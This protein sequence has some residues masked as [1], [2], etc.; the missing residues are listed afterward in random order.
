MEERYGEAYYATGLGPLPYRRDDR[1]LAFFRGVAREIVLGLAPRRVFDAG[2]AMGML[3]ESLWDLGVEAH[4]VDLSRYAIAHVRPDMQPYCRVGSVGEPPEGRYDLVT[5]IEVLEH[6]DRDESE[7]AIAALTTVT[8]TI[9][10]SSTPSDFD[11]PTHVNVRPPIAWIRAFA[12]HGFRVDLRFDATF[13]SPQAM[14]LRRAERYDDG[15]IEELYAHHVLIRSALIEREQ[16]IGRLNAQAEEAAA[17]AE[18]A[19]AAHRAELAAAQA[20]RMQ[21][22]AAAAAGAAQVE[23]ERAAL[24]ALRGRLAEARAELGE[25]RARAAAT[26]GALDQSE[27]RTRL[28]EERAA[29]ALM[30]LGER[31]AAPPVPETDPDPQAFA[32]LARRYAALEARYRR[33]VADDIALA[34]A[35]AERLSGY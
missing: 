21:S 11:E 25:A 20:A 29:L 32:E 17:G 14:L 7:R 1:W 3:V 5:C 12:R 22:E 6:V 8:D 26:G 19:Q 31:E 4:G 16:R 33:L 15:A 9:L 2:C 35:E 18:A 23:A 13:L 24:G 27:H 30:R 10:F 28:A 34:E